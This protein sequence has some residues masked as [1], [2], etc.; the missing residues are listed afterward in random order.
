MNR[1]TLYY[2]QGWSIGIYELLQP[3]VRWIQYLIYTIKQLEMNYTPLTEISSI[4][5]IYSSL[6]LVAV[7]ETAYRSSSLNGTVLVLPESLNRFSLSRLTLG[8]CQGLRSVYVHGS[9]TALSPRHVA[10]TCRDSSAH[11]LSDRRSCAYCLSSRRRS[12]VHGTV[13]VVMLT[14][15]LSTAQT[16][17][18][19][20]YP[21]KP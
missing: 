9:D 7:R 2:T 6:R 18:S 1:G 16:C 13:R 11:A 12:S 4:K 15:R 10:C 19:A 3:Y 17:M 20:E 21:Q 5:S 14:H 8:E